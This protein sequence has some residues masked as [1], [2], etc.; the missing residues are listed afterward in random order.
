MERAGFWRRAVA[1][2]GPWVVRRAPQTALRR[3]I[4]DGINVNVTLLFA[5]EAHRRVIEA[6]YDL[7]G[8]PLRTFRPRWHVARNLA[9]YSAQFC[10][11]VAISLI[12]LAE[13]VSIE[14][15]MPNVSR[16]AM[17]GSMSGRSVPDS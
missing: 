9:H 7:G 13:V 11:F 5:V 1:A 10:W 2:V 3:L 4:A 16:S 6:S 17:R 15:T 8:R 12:P 14:F